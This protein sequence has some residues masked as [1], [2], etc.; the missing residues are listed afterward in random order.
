M[1]VKEEVCGCEGGCV[2]VKEVWGC[3]G[4]VGM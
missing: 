4:G 2:D 3:E 1:D